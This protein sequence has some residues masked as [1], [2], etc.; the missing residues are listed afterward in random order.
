MSAVIHFTFAFVYD[1]S[2]MTRHMTDKMA[3]RSLVA[4]VLALV[5]FANFYD[6]DAKEQ[7]PNFVLML[8]DDVSIHTITNRLMSLLFSIFI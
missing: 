2:H 8:M 3:D 5:L 7:R 1:D 6:A 4:A